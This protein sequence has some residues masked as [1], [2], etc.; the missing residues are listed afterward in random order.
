[1]KNKLSFVLVL[2]LPLWC[3]CQPNPP[4][5]SSVDVP[6]ATS[7]DAAQAPD[8]NGATSEANQAVS[9]SVASWEGVQQLVAQAQGRV[10]VVDVWSSWCPP[11]LREF[12]GLVELHNSHP[13]QV[14]CISVNTN[15]DGSQ[16]SPPE[17]HRETVLGFLQQQRAAFANVMCNIPDLELYQQLNLGAPPAVY[18]YDKA[19][20]LRKRFDNDSAEYGAE[21]FTYRDHIAPLVRELVAE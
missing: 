13:G 9:V 14:T 21:G 7:P 4:T 2:A 10:V 18:V 16:G 11:C 6:P 3:G 20:Q 5:A 17:S 15:Y 12:P 8:A 1:M 19:G